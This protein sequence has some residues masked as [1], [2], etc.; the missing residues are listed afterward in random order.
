MVGSMEVVPKDQYDTWYKSQTEAALKANSP[1]PAAP[2][3]A[4]N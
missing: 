3:T 1:K 4:Q 2:A